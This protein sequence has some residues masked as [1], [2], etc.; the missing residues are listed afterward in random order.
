MTN[1]VYIAN[2]QVH[3]KGVHAAKDFKKGETIFVIKGKRVRLVIQSKKD[4]KLGPHWVGLRK[5]LWVDPEPPAR[6]L[7]HSCNPNAGLFGSVTLKA[8]RRI[9]KGEEITLDYST[10]EDDLMWDFKCACGEKKCRGK[11]RSVQLLPKETFKKYLPFIPRYFQGVYMRY[12][13]LM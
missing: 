4:S 10:T 11:L 9:H 2:S 8:M 1:K 5:H 6:F 7:N 3:G 13:N 12:N